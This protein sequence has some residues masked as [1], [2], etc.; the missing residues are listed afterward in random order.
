MVFGYKVKNGYYKLSANKVLLS[1]NSLVNFAVVPESRE[2]IL[3][4]GSGSED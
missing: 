1:M 3:S 4:A 2:R